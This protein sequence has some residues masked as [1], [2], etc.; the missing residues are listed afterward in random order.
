MGN[1]GARVGD[2]DF[3]PDFDPDSGATSK[4]RLP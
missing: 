2:T 4:M 3:D 1:C